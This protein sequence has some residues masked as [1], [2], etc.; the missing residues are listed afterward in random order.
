MYMEFKTRKATFMG[1][2]RNWKRKEFMV[3]YVGS[4]PAILTILADSN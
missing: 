3:P 1:I 4:R 2:W